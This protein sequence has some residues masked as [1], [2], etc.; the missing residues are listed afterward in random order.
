MRAFPVLAYAAASFMTTGALAQNVGGVP[1]PVIPAGERLF[2]YR[3]AY[4]ARDDGAVDVFAQ[5]FHYQQT[6]APDWRLRVLLVQ[7]KRDGVS[8]KTPT[9]AAQL[10]HYLGA[11]GAWKT[12]VRL[13]GDVALVDGRPDRLRGVWLNEVK[14]AEPLSVRADLFVARQFGDNAQDGVIIETREELDFNL[15]KTTTIG[16]QMFNV[17]GSTAGFGPWSAQRHQ[18]GPMVRVKVGK[19]VKVEASALIGISEAAPDADFR[20]FMGYSF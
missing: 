17:W 9:L 15:S 4:G 19:H 1:S 2:E 7:E 6:I 20:L 10:S 16:A 13:D 14:L 8:L 5:R 11:V 18:L 12:G 3:A